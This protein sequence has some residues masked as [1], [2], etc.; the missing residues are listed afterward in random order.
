MKSLKIQYA[1]KHFEA[2]K[3]ADVKYCVVKDYDE[4]M[5]KVF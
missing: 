4:L 3:N 1:E 2:L 5:R